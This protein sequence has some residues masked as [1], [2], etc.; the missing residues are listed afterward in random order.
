MRPDPW[1]SVIR[2]SRLNKEAIDRIPHDTETQRMIR[3]TKDAKL[4]I[5]TGTV[6]RTFLSKHT[7]K[8]ISKSKAVTDPFRHDRY[9]PRHIPKV[10]EWN[11]NEPSIQGKW[12]YDTPGVVNEN[13][14]S[15]NKF[16]THKCH[17]L[18]FWILFFV[19]KLL[20]LLTLSEL[21]KTLPKSLIEP[22][23]YFIKGG[24]SLFL[25]GLARIDYMDGTEPI[26]YTVYCSDYIPI[27]IVETVDADYFYKKVCTYVHL[28]ILVCLYYKYY[29][30]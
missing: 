13:Q 28:V 15:K 24:L 27:T 1:K 12:C 23:S 18:N 25:G 11:P 10:G 17:F 16:I 3:E 7:F 20:D 14:V 6:G 4:G 30:F 5:L 26:R 21:M 19:C 9:P 2:Y 29:L 22:R 8:E